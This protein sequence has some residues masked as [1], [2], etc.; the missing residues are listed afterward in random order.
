M[1][2]NKMYIDGDTPQEPTPAALNEVPSLGELVEQVIQD[3][4]Y[5]VLNQDQMPDSEYIATDNLGEIID[6]MPRVRDLAKG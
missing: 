6:G 2:Y 1:V 5:R 4:V 3:T